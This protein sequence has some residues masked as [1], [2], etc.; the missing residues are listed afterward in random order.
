MTKAGTGQGEKQDTNC[1]K[2]LMKKMH[3]EEDKKPQGV[4]DITPGP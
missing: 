1:L 4:G 3:P 2:W